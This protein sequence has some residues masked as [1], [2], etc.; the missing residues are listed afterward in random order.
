MAR[1]SSCLA[2]L[3]P[4]MIAA[5]AF[6][7]PQAIDTEK[8]TL[9]VRVGKTGAFSVFG[10]DHEIAAPIQSGSADTGKQTVELRVQAGALKVRDK[11]VS[12]K[13]RAAIQSTMLG[14]EVLDVQRYPEIVF[15]S[16]AGDPPRQGSLKLQ[17]ELTLHGQTRPVTVSVN[18]RDGHY[19]GNAVFKQTDFGI[20][21]VRVAGGTVRVKDEVRIEFDVQLA[22]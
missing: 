11:D 7:Q 1:F 20:A 9:T 6:A 22:R 2:G 4:L 14:P 5:A 15:R 16:T 19:V 13:D 17:G 10:H 12:E 3:L 18:Q 21:P 8:S